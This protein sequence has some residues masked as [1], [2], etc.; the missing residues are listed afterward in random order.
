MES[1]VCLTL[2]H[3]IRQKLR[4][5]YLCFT[6]ETLIKGGWATTIIHVPTTYLA[7][8]VAFVSE[9]LCNRL[10]CRQHGVFVKLELLSRR[11][12]GQGRSLLLIGCREHLGP[13]F[14]ARLT[15]VVPSQLLQDH[16][17]LVVSFL[18]LMYF[19]LALISLLEA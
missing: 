18:W 8:A 14:T 6:F 13:L 2:D 9:I 10:I 7:G 4:Y 17:V 5:R 19:M 15:P 3:Y 1:C 16:L 12:Q 11:S